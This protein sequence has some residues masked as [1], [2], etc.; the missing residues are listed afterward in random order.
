MPDLFRRDQT[1]GISGP[2][3]DDPSSFA[4]HI[5]HA[6]GKRTRFTSVSTSAEAIRDFGE[7]L[8]KLTQPKVTD[9]GH[10]IV[11]HQS[12]VQQ[13]RHDLEAGDDRARELAARALPRARKRLEALVDWRYDLMGTVERKDRITRAEAYVRAYFRR[14]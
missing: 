6:R 13:L 2:N 4:E 12:L 1:N 11:D 10:T 3:P 7:Q 9:E 5:V 8:W 14:G